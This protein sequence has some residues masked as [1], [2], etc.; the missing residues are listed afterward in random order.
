VKAV[1]AE[2]GWTVF[3]VK[4]EGLIDGASGDDELASVEWRE[5]KE[6]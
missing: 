4:T 1:R 6:E 2:V 3:V 5:C